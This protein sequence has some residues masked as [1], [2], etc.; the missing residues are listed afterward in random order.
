MDAI[1]ANNLVIAVYNMSL[2]P[3][4]V[5]MGGPLPQVSGTFSRKA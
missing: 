2:P 5:M 1:E 4:F 3:A